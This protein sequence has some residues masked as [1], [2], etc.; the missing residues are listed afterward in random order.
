MVHEELGRYSL[1]FNFKVRMIS[2]RKK[3]LHFQNSKLSAKL[4]NVL[5]HINNP[6]C[7]A[8]KKILN[9]C[10]LRYMWYENKINIRGG[11]IVISNQNQL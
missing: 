6:L 1:T 10:G 8:I 9:Q 3:L 4:F 11:V 7:E 2:F 5:Q